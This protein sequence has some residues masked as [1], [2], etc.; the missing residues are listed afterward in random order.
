MFSIFLIFANRLVQKRNIKAQRRRATVRNPLK[1]L[2]TRLELQEYTE[3]KTGVAQM[4]L[5]RMK[6]EKGIDMC[7]THYL[8]IISN[9]RKVPT[10]QN[11]QILFC[12]SYSISGLKNSNLA[13]EALAGLAS[14]EDFTAIT[15][16]KAS[17]GGLVFPDAPYKDLMLLQIKGRRHV[18]T[19]LIEPVADNINAGDCFILV[20]PNKVFQ[21]VGEFANVI[22]RSRSAEIS[23]HIQQ[24]GDLGCTA[25]SVITIG[26]TGRATRDQVAEFWKLLGGKPGSERGA[27][28]LDEDEVFE[29]RL[30]DTNMVYELVDDELVPDET[31]WGSIPKIEILDPNKVINYVSL[32]VSI[33]ANTNLN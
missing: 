21:Y 23:L 2:A 8:Q 13:I 6:I 1:A 11:F 7:R 29:S 5:K 20:T 33:L 32:F 24:K 18:Q 27:G 3:I 12:G 30:V 14:Q 25:E 17:E 26:E 19:R 31:F 10:E 9:E 4:E 15:L 28:N 22:E 16:K